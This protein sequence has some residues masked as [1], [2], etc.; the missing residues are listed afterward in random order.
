MPA[1]ITV[2]AQDP[3][4]PAG[5]GPEFGEASP[6][7]L[8]V[9]VVLAIVTAVLIR[10]MTKRLKRLPPS[11][12]PVDETTEDR[13]GET[14]DGPGEKAGTEHGVSPAGRRPEDAGGGRP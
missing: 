4:P 3:A 14:P 9:I 6:I 11:F 5:K 12:D 2:L 7:A 1:V 8:V 10:S 13:P